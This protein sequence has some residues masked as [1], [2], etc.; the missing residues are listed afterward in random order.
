MSLIGKLED[1]VLADIF[2]ILS[3]GRKSGTLVFKGEE[4]SAFVVFRNGVIVR[5]EAS[6]LDG[7]I[8]DELL[9][10]NIVSEDTMNRALDVRRDLPERSIPEILHDLGYVS[11]DVLD[12]LAKKRIENIVYHLLI[13]NKGDFR[14][15][16]DITGPDKKAGIDDTGW[17]FPDGLSVEHLLMESARIQDEEAHKKALENNFLRKEDN[18]S[19]EGAWSDEIQASGR[20]DISMLKA[21]ARELKLR[22]KNPD[23]T[24]LALR[25]VNIFFRRGVLFLAGDDSLA[26]IAQFGFDM[27]EADE[28]VREVSLPYLKSGFL[29]KLVRDKK[30]FRGE[31][32][33]D[34][35]TGLL[36]GQIS[37]E[38]P[39][40]VSVFPLT[41]EGDVAALLYCEGAP[42]DVNESEGVEILVSY[43]G[44]A[45]EKALL[46]RRLH[47]QAG[48]GGN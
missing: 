22:T 47:M 46:K 16:V 33:R 8:R 21:F 39:D 48:E 1:L 14:F 37:G 13:L 3:I 17:E 7:R 5:A 23:I 19:G 27:E 38:W 4:G 15:E 2:Q 24:A 41:I 9:R 20:R 11:R 42:E 25:F 43:A 28:K 40:E 35:V 26:G 18:G 36:V 31:M 34:E 45:L 10:S 44:L 12:S 32:E 6:M 30:I 29:S